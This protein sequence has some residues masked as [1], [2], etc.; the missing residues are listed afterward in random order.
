MHNVAPNQNAFTSA[1]DAEARVSG[2]MARSSD[3]FDVGANS[4]PGVERFCTL[5]KTFE[6]RLGAEHVELFLGDEEARQL[7]KCVI[8]LGKDKSVDMVEVRVGE[9]NRPDSADS[10]VRFAQ[11]L[12]K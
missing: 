10:N 6:P 2:F 3:C 5:M 11:R 7:R 9:G 4:Q 8:A 1:C 12:W